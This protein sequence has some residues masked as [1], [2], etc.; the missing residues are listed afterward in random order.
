[1]VWIY[2]S[3]IIA[4]MHYDIPFIKGGFVKEAKDSTV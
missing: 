3:S 1:M 4:Q 2:A